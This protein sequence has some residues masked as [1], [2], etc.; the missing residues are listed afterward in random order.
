MYFVDDINALQEI[1]I[2]HLKQKRKILEVC[3][4]FQPLSPYQNSKSTKQK[5]KMQ[6]NNGTRSIKPP[7]KIMNLK[8]FF[9]LFNNKNYFFDKKIYINGA[10]K[11]QQQG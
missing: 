7:N 5:D 10:K 4:M 2:L 3:I 11:V 9:F 1:K 8:K 6:I